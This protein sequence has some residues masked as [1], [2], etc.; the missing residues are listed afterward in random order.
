MAKKVKISE[1]LHRAADKHLW[2]GG[3]GTTRRNGDT[4]SCHAIHEAIGKVYGVPFWGVDQTGT[5]AN[6]LWLRIKEGLENLGL[7]CGSAT[8]FR[9]L[10]TMYDRQQSRYAWLKFCAILAEE[11]GV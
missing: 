11:Q 7:N 8:A 3:G 2:S 4:F 1:I 9:E 6:K 5:P 10:P